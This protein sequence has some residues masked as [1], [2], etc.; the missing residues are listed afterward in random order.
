MRSGEAVYN[1]KSGGWG[2]VMASSVHAVVVRFMTESGRKEYATWPAEECAAPPP[3]LLAEGDKNRGGDTAVKRGDL[4]R[5]LE[6]QQVGRLVDTGWRASHRIAVDLSM[7]PCPPLIEMWREELCEIERAAETLKPRKRETPSP[8][9]RAGDPEHLAKVHPH[10]QHVNFVQHARLIDGAQADVARKLRAALPGTIR[11]YA[12]PMAGYLKNGLKPSEIFTPHDYEL[13]ARLFDV[14]NRLSRDG[15]QEVQKEH[16]RLHGGLLVASATLLDVGAIHE[17]PRLQKP[18]LYAEL[19]VQDFAERIGDA[20]VNVGNDLR[21][22]HADDFGSRTANA[23]TEE[24]SQAVSERSSGFIDNIAVGA[25]RDTFRAG[26]ESAFEAIKRELEKQGVKVRFVR[27]S[28]MEKSSCASCKNA[29]GEEV[30]PGEDITAIHEGP[31]ET[32]ECMTAEVG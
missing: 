18:H 14:L 26:R 27:V 17:S 20:V 29:D 21:R 10:E 31:P 16:A 12:L 32:C 6:T 24:L 9:W 19:A 13:E 1:Q 4:V 30:E 3:A 5:N 8:F 28:A 25:A 15:A 22:A 23:I 2:V 7:P 11:R